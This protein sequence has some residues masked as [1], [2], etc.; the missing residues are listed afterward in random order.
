MMRFIRSHHTTGF[1]WVAISSSSTERN[2]F[3]HNALRIKDEFNTKIKYIIIEPKENPVLCSFSAKVSPRCFSYTPHPFLHPDEWRLDCMTIKSKVNG[4]E[5]GC[6]LGLLLF[7]LRTLHRH[8]GRKIEPS[9]AWQLLLPL[10]MISSTTLL[11]QHPSAP[12]SPKLQASYNLYY[13]FS[14]IFLLFLCP[15]PRLCSLS[16]CTWSHMHCIVTAN[17]MPRKKE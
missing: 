3:I 16:F 9:K 4:E 2:A 12:F 10:S 13:S 15:N 6:L 5:S 14:Y 1:V 11:L 7:V 8:H 17:K